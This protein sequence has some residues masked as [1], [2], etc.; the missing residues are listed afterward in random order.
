RLEEVRLQIGRDH[1]AVRRDL[2]REPQRD[3]TAARAD[4]DAAATRPNAET[5]EMRAGAVVERT[6]QP[7]EAEALLG[8]RMVVCVATTHLVTSA[9]AWLCDA[10]SRSKRQSMRAEATAGSAWSAVDLDAGRRAPAAT[11]GRSILRRARHTR[12]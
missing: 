5:Q 9:L 11:M 3:R 8:P 10:M 2:L 4:L 7:R 6:L 12:L 1:L